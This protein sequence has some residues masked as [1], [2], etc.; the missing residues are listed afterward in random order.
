M[1]FHGVGKVDGVF[2]IEREVGTVHRKVVKGVIVKCFRDESDRLGEIPPAIANALN[3][4][5]LA[6][7]AASPAASA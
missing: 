6:E 2:S 1:P 4:G 3:Q 7:S 5:G